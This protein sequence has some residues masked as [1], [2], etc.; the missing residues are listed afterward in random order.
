[1]DSNGFNDT[2][3]F[4]AGVEATISEIHPDPGIKHLRVRDLKA[5]IFATVMKATDPRY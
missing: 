5:V 4:R 3:S 1:M 2:G